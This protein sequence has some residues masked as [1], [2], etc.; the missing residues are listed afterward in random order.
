[1]WENRI[2]DAEGATAPVNSQ[3]QGPCER[4]TLESGADAPAEGIVLSGERT[5]GASSSASS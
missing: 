5:E 2:S 1:M 3:A 4:K